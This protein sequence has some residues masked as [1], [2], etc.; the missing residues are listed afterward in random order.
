MANS[1]DKQDAAGGD[2]GFAADDARLARE[3]K[4]S[5][6]E[7]AGDRGAEYG[8][9]Q[10]YRPGYHEGG[11]RFGFFNGKDDATPG[12]PAKPPEPGD[13]ADDKA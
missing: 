2:G 11:A 8:H 1:D 3:L 12:P 10:N 4:R 6:R 5:D 13:K 7:R 9:D